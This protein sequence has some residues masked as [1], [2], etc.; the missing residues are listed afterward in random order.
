L[1]EAGIGK[2]EV[3]KMSLFGRTHEPKI[4]GWASKA[5]RKAVSEVREDNPASF[6]MAFCASLLESIANF[7]K[8][9]TP[10]PK[11]EAS[12]NLRRIGRRFDDDRCIF[13]AFCY[14]AFRLD[15]WTYYSNG[16]SD[17]RKL[18]NNNLIAYCIKTFEPFLHGADL[19]AVFGSRIDAY[20]SAIRKDS[21]DIDT[22]RNLFIQFVLHTED[23]G[24]LRAYDPAQEGLIVSDIRVT[25]ALSSDLTAFIAAFFE[26]HVE[27]LKLLMKVGIENGLIS[28]KLRE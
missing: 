13:E 21:A 3:Q 23:E 5:N 6:L 12:A 20:S 16:Y 11:D 9:E 25:L 18:L 14:V 24:K 17:L 2:R 4:R 26:I 19:N 7:Y 1:S 15:Y 22:E 10:Y 8:D 27:A 28:D